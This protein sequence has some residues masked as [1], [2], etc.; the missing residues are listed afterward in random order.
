MIQGFKTRSDI[1]DILFRI[2]KFNITVN[3]DFVQSIMSKHKQEDIKL[4]NN[5]VLNSMR[6]QFHSE[7]IINNYVKKKNKG[8]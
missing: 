4:I 6:Y 8:S 2:Y 3:N 7:K 1:H 5:V